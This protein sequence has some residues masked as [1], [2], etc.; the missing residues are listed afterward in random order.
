MYVCMYVCTDMAAGNK[1][2]VQ[3]TEY[4]VPS[5]KYVYVFPYTFSA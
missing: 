4:V 1:Y 3:S 5:H 2:R